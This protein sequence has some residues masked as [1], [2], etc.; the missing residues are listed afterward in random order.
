MTF[1]ESFTNTLFIFYDGPSIGIYS[2]LYNILFPLH[3]NTKLLLLHFD[4]DVI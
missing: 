4:E 1:M 2:E 3:F